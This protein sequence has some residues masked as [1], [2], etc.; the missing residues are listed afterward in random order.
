MWI[1]ATDVRGAMRLAVDATLG[2]T[3]LVEAVHL[4]IARTAL[5]AAP[6]TP[7]ADG[8]AGLVYRGV[9]GVTRIVGGGLG[10]AGAALEAIEGTSPESSPARDAVLAALNGVI[11]D[12]LDASGNPLA[13]PMQWRVD[14]RVL[15]PDAAAITSAFGGTPRS[16]L[17]VLVHGL[18]L[19]DRSWLHGG[20]DHGQSLARDFD[21][22]A[23]YLR[24]NTGRAIGRNGAEL[25]AS[26]EALLDAWPVALDEVHVIAH[27]MGGLVM[28]SAL[29]HAQ[30]LGLRW[31]RRL[32]SVA[33]LGT[34]HHG[35]PLERGGHA[36]DRLLQAHP[37]IA[38][39]ARIGRLRSRGITDLRHGRLL[40]EDADGIAT[41]VPLPPGI[42]FHAIA[43]TVGSTGD[44][45]ADAVLG[46]G[47]VPVD[48]AL[49][50]GGE[51][52]LEFPATHRH[53]VRGV[54]HMGL[55]GDADVHARLAAIA[56]LPQAPTG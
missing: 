18:C 30:A 15:A 12:H 41:H 48:S 13:Q 8:V 36:I 34:P 23:V 39:F 51:R 2:V 25:A 26:I 27:S 49:G 54:G 42:A 31:P 53:V 21:G 28:R 29:H 38:P 9:R 45:L 1:K 32:R 43:A 20:H 4:G 14:G 50:R 11:G 24:Y 52:N 35:A 55:L 22:S 5:G 19:D 33:F 10:L 16:R 7:R 47:L 6:A 44:T 40:D 17:F 56:A 3:D 37:L 46:D